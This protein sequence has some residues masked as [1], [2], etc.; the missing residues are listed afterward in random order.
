PASGNDAFISK[1]EKIYTLN[2]C[3]MCHGGNRAGTTVFPSLQRLSERLSVNQVTEILKTGKGQMPAYP[4]I[5]GEDKKALID[6]LFDKEK[7]LSHAGNIAADTVQKFRYV[8]N[9]W[10][11]LTDREGYPGVKPPWGT[12][13]AIDLNAGKILW[14]VPLG[15]YEELTQKGIPLTGTQN[16]GGAVVTAGRLV[17]IGATRDEKLRIFDKLSGKI[18]WEYKLPAGGYAMPATY[19][20]N[21]KQY[22]VI[23]AGGGGKVG[24][25]SGDAYVAFRLKE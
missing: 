2:N 20:L 17:I 4:N 22:I 19:M 12:L 16:L 8:H 1:G 6:F 18:L 23:A 25:S 24:S 14:Q 7:K 21:G 9:G 13:N 3:T 11:V 15:E 5:S 10:T